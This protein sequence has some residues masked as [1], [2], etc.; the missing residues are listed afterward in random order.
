MTFGLDFSLTKFICPLCNKPIP[1]VDLVFVGKPKETPMCYWCFKD[2]II[3]L[4]Q[5][6][7]AQASVATYDENNTPHVSYESR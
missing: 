1:L 6:L 4:A 3:P 5:A 2:E 7:G